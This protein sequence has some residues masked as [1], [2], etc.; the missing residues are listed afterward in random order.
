VIT[1]AATFI[2]TYHTASVIQV[3]A[4]RLFGHAE[5]LAPVFE[6]HEL[7]HHRVYRDRDLLLDQ[8]IPAEK[9]VMWYF[10][11]LFTPMVV[12]FYV[13][14]PLAIF[15]AHAWGIAFAVW[16]HVFLHRHYHL[17]GSVFERFKWFR[18]KRQ[19]HFIHHRRVHR[20]YAIVEFWLDRLLGTMEKPNHRVEI[21]AVAR[22]TRTR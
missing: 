9:H 16:W 11:P 7:G 20:N 15:V 10:V 2:A 4:H 6:A 17:R 8:W 3:V 22:L 1:I 12:T 14:A 5:R 19:L 21:D 18:L 13:L